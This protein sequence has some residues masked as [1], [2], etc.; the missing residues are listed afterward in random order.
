MGYQLGEVLKKVRQSKRYTQKYV[1]DEEMSRATYA[2]IEACSMQPTV[3]KFMHILKKLDITYDELTYIQHSYRLSGKEEIIHDLFQLS[4]STEIN[5]LHSLNFKCESYLKDNYDNVVQDISYVCKANISIHNS[6]NFESALP[7][8]KKVWERLSKLDNWYSIELKLINN[9]FYFFP[10]DTAIFIAKKALENINRFSYIIRNIEL[11]SSYLLNISILL[12]KDHKY[13]E[14]LDY[15]EKTIDECIRIKRYEGLAVAYSRK[16][17]SLINLENKD[18]GFSFIR[19]AL[20]ICDV[21]NLDVM[22]KAIIQEIAELTSLDIDH[23]IAG[24][25]D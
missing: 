10:L 1:A 18:K 19:K 20:S 23:F 7:Y 3:G 22:R 25:T 21:L 15:A 4:F 17:M 12:I 8:A 14:A 9:I 16:G 5:K 11:K 24:D 6:K 2:K 13:Q